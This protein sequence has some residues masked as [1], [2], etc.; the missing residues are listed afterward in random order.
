MGRSLVEVLGADPDIDL[1]AIDPT[2]RDAL[3]QTLA[4][5]PNVV[6][7]D[8]RTGLATTYEDLSAI[9]RRRPGLALLVCTDNDER[10]AQQAVRA[11][12]GGALDYVTKPKAASWHVAAAGL[13]ERLL[14]K[15]KRSVGLSEPAPV[16]APRAKPAGDAE[17]D[18]RSLGGRGGAPEV[19]LIGASTGGP[20]ALVAVL[21]ALPA[22]FPLPILVVQHMPASFVAQF[23]GRLRTRS[24]FEVAQGRPGAAVRPGQVWIAPGD[25]HMECARSAHGVR[26]RLHRDGRIL[27]SPPAVDPLLKSAAATYGAGC[28]AVV[29]TGMGQ[30]GLAGCRAVRRAGGQVLVQDRR[31]SVV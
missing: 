23:A 25:F 31:T 9:A 7:L 2:H 13:R 19:L 10:G 28:L 1:V 11:L 27:T 30:D 15:V 24:R 17:S 3:E 29:F 5:R 26:L 4:A 14:R 21:A 22:E 8:A 20:E 12:A 16:P 18:A 6:I